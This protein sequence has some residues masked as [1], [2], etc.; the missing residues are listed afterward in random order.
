M[1][2]AL[3]PPDEQADQG[4]NQ[5]HDDG[6]PPSPVSLGFKIENRAQCMCNRIPYASAE[7]KSHQCKQSSTSADP[8]ARVAIEGHAIELQGK[9]KP[10]QP[11]AD[12]AEDRAEYEADQGKQQTVEEIQPHGSGRIKQDATHH[13]A[14]FRH[15]DVVGPRRRLRIHEFNP[16]LLRGEAAEQGRVGEAQ[17]LAG[18]EHDQFRLQPQQTFKM[19]FLKVGEV[20]GAPV[21]DQ[22]VRGDDQAGRV[23]LAVDKNMV[24]IV[25]GEQ[26]LTGA[27][28][29]M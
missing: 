23:G 7:Y 18:A 25:T 2:R 24:V 4:Q 8:V 17:L 19:S 1:G 28:A 6:T 12:E 5:Q 3:C 13:T 22:L 21:G 27:V 26:I 11:P 9:P 20:A 15:Q 10:I 14:V 16:D 29:E